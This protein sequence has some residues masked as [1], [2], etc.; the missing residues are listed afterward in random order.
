[1]IT[2]CEFVAA[3]ALA[4]TRFRRFPVSY[5]CPRFGRGVSSGGRTEGFYIA[6]MRWVRLLEEE[7]KTKGIPC[8][9][10]TDLSQGDFTTTVVHTKS[11]DLTPLIEE[12][13][14][15]MAIT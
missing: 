9:I 15:I 12:I 6:G 13:R 10:Y 2:V 3:K 5:A 11:D 8:I 4:N 7:A 14:K 1:M